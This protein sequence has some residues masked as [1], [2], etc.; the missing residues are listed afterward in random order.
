VRSEA[1][2]GWVTDKIRCRL[3]KEQD[4]SLH[5]HHEQVMKSVGYDSKLLHGH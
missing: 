2:K 1:T 5:L 3:C 4:H